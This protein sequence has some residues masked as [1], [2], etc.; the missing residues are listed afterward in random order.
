MMVDG[1]SNCMFTMRRRIFELG[2]SVPCQGSI[3][4]IGSGLNYSH[5]VT[6]SASFDGGVGVPSVNMSMLYTP[7]GAKNIISE[8]ILLD[9]YGIEVNKKLMQVIHPCGANTPLLR[10]R[11]L[12]YADLT[13]SAPVGRSRPPAVASAAELSASVAS[14]SDEALLWAARMGLGADGLNRFLK[15]VKGVGIEKVP[16]SVGDVIDSRMDRAIAQAKH[17]PVGSTPVS[18]LATKPGQLLICDGFGKHHAASPL[19]GAVYQFH[20]VDERS[21][22]GFSATG[23]THTVEDWMVFLRDVKLQAQKH[24]ATVERVRFDRAPELRTDELKRRAAKELN[25]LVELTAR[26][27]HEGV[28]RAERNNDLLTRMAE[29]MLQRAKLGTAWLL[30]AR[31]YA[32]WLLNRTPLA[33]TGETRFQQFRA[34]VPNFGA[35]LTPYVFGTTVSIVE[36]VKG[37]K[38]SLEHP[39]GSV[40]R[41][42]G[43][44]DSSYLVWR[45][46]RKNVVHQ[47]SVNALNEKALIATQLPPA[48]AGVEMECQTEGDA[49]V[50]TELAPDDPPFKEQ[51]AKPSAAQ[52]KPC[53]AVIDIADGTRIEVL[54]PTHDGRWAW[55]EGTVLGFVEQQNGKR[56]HEV[57]YKGW[58]A[59]WAHNL[60]DQGEKEWRYLDESS[61]PP[62]EDSGKRVTRSRSD[63]RDLV[64]L[65]AACEMVDA[66]L[67][68]TPSTF[69]VEGERAQAEAFNAAV[70]QALGDEGSNYECANAGD[71]ERA[72]MLMQ[73]GTMGER[74]PTVKIFDVR[75][76]IA[77]KASQNVID[78]NTEIGTQQFVVPSSFKQAANGE[79]HMEWLEADRKALEA[80]LL[81]PGNRLV[82]ISVP[83]EGGLPIARCVTQR[84]IKV[85]AATGRLESRN[86]FKARHCVDGAHLQMLLTRKGIGTT[87]DASSSVADEMLVKMLLADT[88]MRG[89]RLLKADVPNAYPQGKR[90]GRP[91][92]YMA[93]PEAFQHMKAEDG[94]QL[95]IELSTPM[96]GERQAGFE[97]QLEL[98]KTLEGLGWRRAEN[99][100]ACW[101]FTSDEGDATLVTIVDDMLFSESASSNYRISERTVAKLSGMY[102]D[103]RP[104]REPTSFAGYSLRYQGGRITISVPQKVKEAARQHLPGLLDDATVTEADRVVLKNLPTGDKLVKMADGMVMP[105]RNGKPLKPSQRSTQALIGSLKFVERCHPRA[106]LMLHRLSCV[107]A[108]P[109]PE[110]YT[111]ARA[112]L[113][114]LYAERDVGITYGS[115]GQPV[116]GDEYEL[117]GQLSSEIKGLKVDLDGRPP[118][119]LEAHADATWG[120]LNVYGLLLT[121]GGGV[122]YHVTKKIALI[123]DSSM[124]TEAIASAKAGEQVA[125]ARDILRAFGVLPERPTLIGTD[126]LANFKVATGIGCPSRSRHF[127]RRYFVLKRRIASGEVTMIHVPDVEMPA[128]CLTKWLPSAKLRR[129]VEY[130]TGA[131]VAPTA[132][133]GQ[134][135]EMSAIEGAIAHVSEAGPTAAHGDAGAASGHPH[136]GNRSGD[137]VG[138]S[139]V[140]GVPRW[141]VVG[142]SVTEP[143]PVTRVVCVTRSRPA[144]ESAALRLHS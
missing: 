131:R 113:A 54:W 86:A 26:E 76:A 65:Q 24:G 44:T 104:E 69:G 85:D 132:N 28:G 92:T 6:A 75:R 121:F 41:I 53:P 127:L 64:A 111:V 45:D 118:G 94:S 36:D 74:E 46:A 18:G 20:A 115:S 1:G 140:G 14:A 109:P 90:M 37:P 97:W 63:A 70:Y 129:S 81:Y 82:P 138:G 101:R 66:V 50:D 49:R 21:S 67:E 128:D 100:P 17:A 9:E 31:A 143:T 33:K 87:S 19:D 39:R 116:R 62:A 55:Y 71:I 40:G 98:E 144:Q 11:G 58:N 79:Q 10:E 141:G 34:E 5:L 88:A 60:A 126:N 135:I 107:M 4:G 139:V 77:C 83:I 91:L 52:K 48:V 119:E 13:F 43:V 57:L 105:E 61:Q 93:M 27:H 95:C 122:V 25:I 73:L 32:Q 106:S 102:G 78:V 125:V 23:K 16:K 38:G 35:G 130:M 29:E 47:T 8:S 72:R 120:Q 56:R 15:A 137:S 7:G 42:V 12:F 133:T 89:R 123:V 110:A 134:V 124:E 117:K 114:S 84:R 136:R 112:V 103:L 2:R 108:C 96:W 30:P 3:G 99:V 51:R 22:Y 80:I 142:A 59:S 68:A